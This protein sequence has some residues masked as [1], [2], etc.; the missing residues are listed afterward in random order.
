MMRINMMYFWLP[1]R[2]CLLENVF[3][4]TDPRRRYHAYESHSESQTDNRGVCS[5]DVG[6]RRL[7]FL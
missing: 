1:I 6:R 5:P 7:N 4:G 3:P 2:D